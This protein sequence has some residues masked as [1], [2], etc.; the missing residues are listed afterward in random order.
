LQQELLRFPKSSND[1]GSESANYQTGI[2]ELPGDIEE[3]H[4]WRDASAAHG[5]RGALIVTICA[6]KAES[7]RRGPVAKTKPEY[8]KISLSLPAATI[9]KIE[10]LATS[11]GKSKS[12]IIEE[13]LRF[14]GTKPGEVTRESRVFGFNEATFNSIPLGGRGVVRPSRPLPGRE[15]STVPGRITVNLSGALAQKINDLA[16][17]QGISKNGVVS[18]LVERAFSPVPASS[19]PAIQNREQVL[20]YSHAIIDA[21]QEALD[22]D[23]T[24]H[25]NQAPPSLRLDDSAYLEEIRRLVAELQRLNDLL[26]KS[27]PNVRETERAVSGLSKHFNTFLESYAK[28]LGVGAAGLTIAAMAALLYQAGVSQEVIDIIWGHVK[29]KV[30][31]TLE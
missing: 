24:R 11:Q 5:E 1:G 7:Q 13:T 25:H 26:E 2:T 14:L 3:R 8:Q 31:G 18:A 21:L 28:T 16:T 12:T 17:S 19:P 23:A 20:R 22:Y 6:I 15:S 30:G 4:G 9:R 10:S 29:P 27:R